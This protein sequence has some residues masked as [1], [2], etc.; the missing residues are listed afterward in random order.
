MSFQRVNLMIYAFISHQYRNFSE[1]LVGDLIS[2]LGLFLKQLVCPARNT[3][4]KIN[5]ERMSDRSDHRISLY[6]FKR[7]WICQE[8]AAVTVVGVTSQWSSQVEH[9]TT[10]RKLSQIT[11]MQP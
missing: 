2:L 10:L 4:H 3:V 7:G 9:A 11:V 8:K 6:V 1:R 5:K